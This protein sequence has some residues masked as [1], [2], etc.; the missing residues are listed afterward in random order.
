[1][2]NFIKFWGTRGSCS[3]SGHEYVHFGGNTPCLEINYHN[4]RV[5]I[6]AGTGIH[7]LGKQLLHETVDEIHLFI[8]H[9]HWDH[10][11]GFPFFAPIYHSDAQIHIWTPPSPGR[12][13]KDLFDDLLSPEF[14][15]VRLSQI[16]GQARIDFHT[17][18]PNMPVT[19]GDLK[20]EFHLAC[21]PST[22][23]CFK[24]TTPHQTIGYVTDNEMLQHYHGP[25]DNVPPDILEPH[26]SLIQF[27]SDCDLLVHEAQYTP[28]EYVKRAG[29][30]HS[31][32][33]NAVALLLQTKTP[34][35]IVTHHDPDH[36]D[37]DLHKMHLATKELLKETGSPCT[38]EWA[39][40]G[41][42]LKLK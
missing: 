38:V 34:Q 41:L 32:Y 15:P 31:S 26:V 33:R 2:H 24:I 35:W 6:D 30:G 40:D 29:W 36:S 3:V 8:G 13:C 28:E 11:I 5:I 39:H 10:L 4:S 16:Q 17:A 19:F 1:M 25:L 23:Y 21:H 27:L 42:V 20:I 12:P 7:M 22:T 18:H 37:K 14:F 9:T